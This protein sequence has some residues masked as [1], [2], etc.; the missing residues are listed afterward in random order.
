MISDFSLL[1]KTFIWDIN[2]LANNWVEAGP[3]NIA[4]TEF[5]IFTFNGVIYAAGGLDDTGTKLTSVEEFDLATKTWSLSSLVL[6]YGGRAEF[7][8]SCTSNIVHLFVNR[9]FFIYLD[10]N[11]VFTDIIALPDNVIGKFLLLTCKY[12]DII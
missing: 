12:M 3:L 11:L 7:A 8:F 4:R 5:A 6:P 10:S 1:D 9:Q 2:A